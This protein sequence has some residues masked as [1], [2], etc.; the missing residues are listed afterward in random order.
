MTKYL[1]S[2]RYAKFEVCI[3]GRPPS[4]SFHRAHRSHNGGDIVMLRLAE[5]QIP[6]SVLCATT[7]F[8]SFFKI[9]WFLLHDL[10]NQNQKPRLPY[11]VLKKYIFGDIGYFYNVPESKFTKQFLWFEFVW[12]SST[13]HERPGRRFR[14]KGRKIAII[15]FTRLMFNMILLQGNKYQ[16]QSFLTVG[17]WILV[18]IC[19]F[20]IYYYLRYRFDLWI[21]W[22]FMKY[23]VP[24]LSRECY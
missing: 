6:N 9:F 4:A 19:Y 2:V 14:N 22:C 10:S 17:R 5:I 1:R 7:I 12:I 16:T 21:E 18:N 3:G 8:L 24:S 20:I 15:G 23:L 11:S 13:L